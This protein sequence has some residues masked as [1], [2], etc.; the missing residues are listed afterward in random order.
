MTTTLENMITYKPYTPP[1][2][3]IIPPELAEIIAITQDTSVQMLPLTG[4]NLKNH[5]MA[6]V[7]QI[8][9]MIVGYCAGTYPYEQHSGNMMEVGSLVVVPEFRYL[10]I[11]HQLVPAVTKQVHSIGWG[12]IAFCNTASASIFTKAGYQLATT[13][14]V[15]PEALGPCNTC[16]MQ[17]LHSNGVCCD[18]VYV[19]YPGESQ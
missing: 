19:S 12:A 17:K 18:E 4:E 16:P 5:H 13:D 7:A 8:G 11:A 15:P 3:A 2:S 10:G 14:Q 6:V 9:E 1:K